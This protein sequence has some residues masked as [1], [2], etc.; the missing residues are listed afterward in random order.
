MTSMD[1]LMIR[2]TTRRLLD[3][4]ARNPS[5]ALLLSGE[6]GAGLM[7]LATTL[8][9]GENRNP[10]VFI[11]P[12]KGLIPIVRIKHL[13]EETRGIHKHKQFIIIDD[14]DTMS[15]DAQNALLKLLEEPVTNM[16]FILTSHRP[17]LILK[18]IASRTQHI[19]ILPVSRAGSASLIN[20]YELTDQ[21]RQQI[22]FLATGRPAELVRL[23]TDKGYFAERAALT[24]K[25]RDFLQLDTYGRL[26]IIDEI[27]D[28]TKALQ[29]LSVCG[30]LLSYSLFKQKN[31]AITDK[32]ELIENTIKRLEA[33]GHVRTQLM[34]LVTKLP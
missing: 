12:E 18:T 1:E 16:H 14:A 24:T 10:P 7:T 4:Y 13:Y 21:T 9:I 23:A 20:R 30:K 26:Q 33:N 28:R 3:A 19:R 8:S 2:D 29:F 6:V 15:V 25:V 11:Q 34:Y 31:I 32:L 5:H 17:E 27:T 22:L